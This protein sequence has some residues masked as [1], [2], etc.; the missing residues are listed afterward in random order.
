MRSS[1]SAKKAKKFSDYL[2]FVFFYQISVF[3]EINA[4][5]D[6]MCT[7]L[8]QPAAATAPP[9]Q[10]TPRRSRVHTM[11][12]KAQKRGADKQLTKDDPESEDDAHDED[13]YG[14]KLL[15]GNWVKADEARSAQHLLCKDTH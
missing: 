3:S 15:V 10:T 7:Y 9:R 6:W 5:R 4:A 12:G 14:P 13:R 11:S 2:K 1:R 8:K